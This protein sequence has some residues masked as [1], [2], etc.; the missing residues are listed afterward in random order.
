MFSLT[1]KAPSTTIVVFV[2]SV[3]QDQAARFVIYTVHFREA[4]CKK[5]DMIALLFGSKFYNKNVR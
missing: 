2:A 4:L 5:A 3:D 1:L